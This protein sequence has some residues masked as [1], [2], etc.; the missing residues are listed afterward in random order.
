MIYHF[1]L[2]LLDG[3]MLIV[4]ITIRFVSIVIKI[5]CNVHMHFY[6]LIATFYQYKLNMSKDFKKSFYNL[7]TRFLT[8]LLNRP[9]YICYTK[10]PIEQSLSMNFNTNDEEI[11]NLNIYILQRKCTIQAFLKKTPT[12]SVLNEKMVKQTC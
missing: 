8:F 5:H 1:N 7:H 11:I 12:L 10:S 2:N 6:F 9:Q 3:Y 4:I